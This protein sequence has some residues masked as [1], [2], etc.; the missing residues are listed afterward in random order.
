MTYNI[1]LYQGATTELNQNIQKKFGLGASVVLHLI[2]HLE[3]N[4]HFLYFDNFF[5]T[6]NL[7]R[8]VANQPNLRRWY[9]KN[10]SV[11]KPTLII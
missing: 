3:K 11:R 4:R 8:T 1:L 9:Y 7:F 6:F 2:Q 10:Q 5:S